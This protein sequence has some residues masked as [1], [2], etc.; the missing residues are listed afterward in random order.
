MLKVLDSFIFYIISFSA[1]KGKYTKLKQ[2]DKEKK[3]DW[4]LLIKRMETMQLSSSEKEIIKH[5]IIQKESEI[6]RKKLFFKKKNT[7]YLIFKDEKKSLQK[8]L[9]LLQ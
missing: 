1:N 6:L 9:I 3:E 7:K 4:E 5:D 2:D 8:I